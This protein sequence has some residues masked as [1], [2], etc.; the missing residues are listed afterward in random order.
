MSSQVPSAFLVS[1]IGNPHRFRRD[2]EALGIRVTGSRFF[3]DHE[4]PTARQWFDCADAARSSSAEA[5]LTTEK[6]AIRL[7]K[8]PDFPVLVA[9][10]TSRMLEDQEFAHLILNCIGASREAH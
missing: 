8:S 6:D 1:A 3:R 4:A 5:I 7:T 2:V 9:R 10:Q